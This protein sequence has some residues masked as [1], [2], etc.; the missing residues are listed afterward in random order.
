MSYDIFV[1][2]IPSSAQHVNDIPKDFVPQ[3]IGHRSEII[4]VITAVAPEISFS[5]PSWGIIKGGGW[6]IEVSL[7]REE[8]MSGFAFH[9]RGGGDEPLSIVAEILKRLKLRAIVPDSDTGLFEP[10]PTV[11]EAFRKWQQYRDQVVNR[12]ANSS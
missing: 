3:S 10:G 8:E 11:S 4:A 1:Q 2:D 6:S 7:G 9:L 12:N 5:D